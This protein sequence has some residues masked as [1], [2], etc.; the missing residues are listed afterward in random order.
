MAL[1]QP[2][3][4][5]SNILTKSLFSVGMRKKNKETIKNMTKTKA[6]ILMIILMFGMV[7][8]QYFYFIF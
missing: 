6:E 1:T 8:L 5:P 3:T 4:L 2:T 7:I